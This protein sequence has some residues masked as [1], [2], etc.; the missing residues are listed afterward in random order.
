MRYR[1]VQPRQF[2]APTFNVAW[3]CDNTAGKPRTTKAT[4]RSFGLL[5]LPMAIPI[6]TLMRLPIFAARRDTCHDMTDLLPLPPLLGRS[7]PQH[8]DPPL[9]P[10]GGSLLLVDRR[11]PQLRVHVGVCGV[12]PQ[13]LTSARDFYS[14][15]F[16]YVI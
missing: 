13:G 1:S 15:F 6:Q 4:K 16:P 2:C 10:R 14:V 8:S 12:P 3:S 5:L 7:D 11:A 9:L